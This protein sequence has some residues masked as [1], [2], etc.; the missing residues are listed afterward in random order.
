[1]SEQ[2]IEH[3]LLNEIVMLVVL[4]DKLSR[5]VDGFLASES[6]AGKAEMKKASEEWRKWRA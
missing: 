4:G 6:P 3:V 5:C 1:M 2:T